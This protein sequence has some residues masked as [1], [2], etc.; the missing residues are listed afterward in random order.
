MAKT[1]EEKIMLLRPVCQAPMTFGGAAILAMI[2][3]GLPTSF[4]ASAQ[5]PGGQEHASHV[6][7]VHG[8]PGGVPD[9]CANPTVISSKSGPWSDAATWGAGKIPSGNDRV[10]IRAGDA[11]T[12]DTASSADI[13]CIEVQGR[14]SFR[15]DRSTRLKTANIMVQ[16]SGVLEVGTPANPVAAGA[17]AEI[18]IAD[19]NIDRKV[20]PAELGNGI[21]ALGR[22]TMSG[23]PKAPTFVRVAQELSAGQRTL[24]AEQGVDAWRA[25][26]QL[27]IPDTRQL[28]ENERGDNYRSEDEKIEIAD[29]SGSR[30]TLKSPLKYDHK[31][32]RD[33]DGKLEFLP[34]VGNLTR[35][36]RVR[37]EN[38]AGTRG[39]MIFMSHAEVD[40]RYVE[41]G[42]MGR[43]KMG[44]LDSTEFEAQRVTHLGE[45][46][47]GR[48]GIH[49]HHYFGPKQTPANGYQFT[50]I[51][52]S[53]DGA[54]KW[55][56]TVHNSHYGL[57]RD[58]VVYNTKG[59]G[60]VTE[61]GTE[62]FNVFDHN[63]A[64]RSQG[65]GEFAPVSGYGGVGRDPG[66]EGSGFWFRGP[67]NYIRN[68]VAANGDVFGFDLAAGSLGKVRIPKFKGADMAD[69]RETAEI[70][71]TDAKVLEF[72]NNEAYGAIQTGVAFGWNG[73]IAN[74]RA[75]NPSRHG[76]TATP[77]DNL[78]IENLT[79]RGDKTVLSNEI[80]N[81][82]G[83]WISNYVA[84][85]VTVKNADIQGMR[86]GVASPFFRGEAEPGRGD[87]SVTVENG[88]FRDY[89]GVVVATA[90]TANRVN[91]RPLKRAIV[92]DSSFEPLGGVRLFEADPP[93]SISMNYRMA[94][95]DPEPRDPV[96]VF[97]YNKKAGDDFKVY[98]SLDPNPRISP[99]KSARQGI[100]G[101]VCR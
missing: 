34:H 70:D 65:S 55:G 20:D 8:V 63:F 74:F 46:Q 19:R 64:M 26:D 4:L 6:H 53:I 93:A 77:A 80:E 11:V 13:V 76:V 85:S 32:A 52:T 23:S 5:E 24:V 96:E 14:L 79:V 54:P 97:G 42:E 41:V 101:W 28:R 71:T 29:V 91:G 47:I 88:R 92:R 87:G 50:L 18:V 98:Y 90:Y 48:Y 1:V 51:G 27:V 37:S 12:Y 30:I 66:G 73:A 59:A 16:E 3:S 56:I 100:G 67:N 60:I 22:V 36:V 45:N 95:D 15:T 78:T 99:C 39:H 9:W 35:N 10:L 81:P 33:A 82:T 72:S 83:V 62:S 2:L 89:L 17:L 86:T 84:K 21:E 43:T 61:D 68:N 40:L 75:W 94:P 31:G 49:F 58:N 69:D 38:P 25:G 57:I 7:E 44:V